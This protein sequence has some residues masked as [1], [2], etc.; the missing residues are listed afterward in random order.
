MAVKKYD[1]IVIGAGLGGLSAAT[2]LARNRKRVLLLERHNVPGG[3]STSFVRG[4]YE[5][6]IALHELA[7][8][9][10]NNNGDIY[11][12]LDYLGVANKVEFIHVENMY[13]SIFRDLDVTLPKGREA[14]EGKLCETFPREA[15]GIRRFLGRVFDFGGEFGQLARSGKAPKPLEVARRYPKVFRYLPVTWG[16]VL[17]RDVKDPYARAVISQYWGYFG[18]PPSQLSFVYFALGLNSYIKYGPSW[19]KGRSQALGNAFLSRFEELGGEVRMNAGAKKILTENG[20]VRGVIT[21][22][23]QEYAADWVLSNAD[24]I[25]TCR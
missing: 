5:F 22:D 4:R 20:R 3:Y 21:D 8:V 7:G 10:P 16:Q 15:D 6:E 18:M 13:R 24:P 2:M 17:Y 23:E 25:T 9:G 19:I 14:Y 1:A 12:Y 11:R